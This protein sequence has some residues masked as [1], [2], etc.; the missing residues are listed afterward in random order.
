MNA[1][2]NISFVCLT[3]IIKKK[4]NTLK[5]NL[6]PVSSI[7]SNLIAGEAW[8]VFLLGPCGV[9]SPL[10]EGDACFEILFGP[11]SS[12]TGCPSKT[13]IFF[14]YLFIFKMLF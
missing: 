14:L 5:L 11:S 8:E 10:L 4:S 12:Y 3:I 6:P 7:I 13:R 1:F 2:Q 9:D